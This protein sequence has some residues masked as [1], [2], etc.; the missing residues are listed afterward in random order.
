[1]ILFLYNA[2]FA[3]AFLLYLPIML[4]KLRRRGG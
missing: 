1:M 2:L 4:L 3:V